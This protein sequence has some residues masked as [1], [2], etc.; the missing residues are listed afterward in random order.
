VEMGLVVGAM[1]KLKGVLRVLLITLK[2]SILELVIFNS[3]G[4]RFHDSSAISCTTF[5][6]TFL[7][8]AYLVK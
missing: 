6:A 2:L 3:L 4:V 5:Q 1:V 7:R 8:N